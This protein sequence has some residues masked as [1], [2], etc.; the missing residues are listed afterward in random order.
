[1]CAIDDA[2]HTNGSD[3]SGYIEE[4][5]RNGGDCAAESQGLGICRKIYML[6]HKVSVLRGGSLYRHLQM[7]GTKKPKPCKMLPD[8]RTQK[9][10]FVR[11][12]KVIPHLVVAETGSRGLIKIVTGRRTAKSRPAHMRSVLRKP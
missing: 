11:K 10:L 2:S 5:E 12:V 3:D 4:N 8:C 9:V 6:E 7:D 1:M